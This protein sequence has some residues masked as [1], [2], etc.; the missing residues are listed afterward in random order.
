VS[1]TSVESYKVKHTWNAVK[2]LSE[3]IEQF[4]ASL[5]KF[6]DR[7]VV[8][9]N[10]ELTGEQITALIK[11]AYAVRLQNVDAE[12]I[13]ECDYVRRREDDCADAYTVLNRIQETVIRG[14]ISYRVRDAKGNLQHR[15][16]RAVKGL[17][18]NIK[19][20]RQIF[21]LVNNVVAA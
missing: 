8:M 17:A 4:A 3:T 16:T 1:G 7:L 9:Q 11:N 5:P 15:R 20:N 19:L 12:Y 2:E 14:G 6:M 13:E 18:A 10:T 21:D